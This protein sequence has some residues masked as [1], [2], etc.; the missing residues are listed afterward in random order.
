MVG[1]WCSVVVPQVVVEGASR[2]CDGRSRSDEATRLDSTRPRTYGV[3]AGGATR[4][5]ITT[6]CV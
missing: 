1:G 2:A 5:S 3:L 4:A 6:V